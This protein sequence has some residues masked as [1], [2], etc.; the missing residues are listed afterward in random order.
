MF[1]PSSTPRNG[2]DRNTVLTTQRTSPGLS[3]AMGNMD[4]HESP[5][6]AK[7]DAKKAARRALVPSDEQGAVAILGADGISTLIMSE[8]PVLCLRGK[9]GAVFINRHTYG[10][11]IWLAIEFRLTT[12][13][14]DALVL[15]EG[16]SR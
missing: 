3:G 13:P 9:L 8:L 1:D 16:D 15:E 5:P 7:F 6:G 12:F 2:A 4:M 10:R 14:D 11:R